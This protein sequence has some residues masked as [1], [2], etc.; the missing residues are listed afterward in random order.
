MDQPLQV[1]PEQE[2]TLS[3][4]ENLEAFKSFYFLI[5][6]KRDTEIKLFNE[7]KVFKREDITELNTRISRKLKNFNV[8]SS[9]TNVTINLSNK[10]C[11]DFGLWESFVGYDWNLVASQTK[12]ITIEWDF[13]VVLPNQLM[14]KVPQ[15][16]TVRVRLGSNLRPQEFF[17]VVM[18]GG[19]DH[20]IE[21]YVSEMVCKIDFVNISL[22]EDIKNTVTSWYEALPK[23]TPPSK[24]EDL[25]VRHRGKLDLSIVF[26]CLL[27]CFCIFNLG[28]RAVLPKLYLGDPA[29]QIRW[30][31]FMTTMTVPFFYLALTIG[32][33]FSE[34][35]IMGT[36]RKFKPN[37][38]ILLTK[39][40]QNKVTEAKSVNA[41]L[42]KEFWFKLA[43]TVSINIFLVVV[44]NYIPAVF[45]YLVKYF[46]SK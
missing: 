34:K 24:L 30:T 31:I 3:Q 40:D 43:V 44:A 27:S 45:G 15:T 13:N 41:Q 5:K 28:C 8:N 6:S 4:A 21:E 23:N 18:N 46:I 37:P 9:L 38:M 35:I 1:I 32:R 33:F 17:H 10:E 2:S 11:Q 22:C 36:I 7:N 19:E 42:L 26:L 20:E 14:P 25:I 12:S 16:H 29:S 39:G